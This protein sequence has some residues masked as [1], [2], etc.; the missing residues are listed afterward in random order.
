MLTAPAFSRRLAAFSLIAAPILLLAGFALEP[1]W[2]DDASAYLAEIA[3]NETR[4]GIWAG[5]FALA[6]IVLLPGLLGT[7]RLLRGPRGAIGQIGAVALGVS[8]VVIGGIVLAISVTEIAMVDAT[9][10]RAQMAALYD[11]TQ[12]VTEGTIVFGVVWFGGFVLGTLILA[13]GLLLRRVVP[14]WSPLLLVGWMAAAFF[15]EGRVGT[16]VG[17]LLLLGALAPIAHRIASLSD[18]EWARWQPLPASPRH[19]RAAMPELGTGV[20]T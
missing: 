20:R 13:V 5:L 8:A 7:A 1:A 14:F 12:E 15:L 10:D 9:A 17:S 3:G 4:H 18:E 6:T 16:L 2:N 11:R 19:A